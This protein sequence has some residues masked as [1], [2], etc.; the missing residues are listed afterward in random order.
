V[1]APRDG[2]EALDEEALEASTM[3]ESRPGRQTGGALKLSP[4][5]PAGPDLGARIPTPGLDTRSSLE[6]RLT[7]PAP[8]AEVPPAPPP[9][10]QTPLPML[11]PSEPARPIADPWPTGS[12]RR[13]DRL[14]SHRRLAPAAGRGRA[15]AIA[16]GSFLA[17]LLVRDLVRWTWQLARPATAVPA[18]AAGVVAPAA[19]P[20]VVPGRLDPAAP[21]QPAIR[22]PADRP[23]SPGARSAR[24]PRDRAP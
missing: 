12:A 14:A 18:P 16:L 17:G 11:R 7:L 2:D 21:G 3:I 22:P 5:T 15:L 20:A 8:V 6:L 10:V 23:G 9:A 19:G 24:R 13:Q 1:S 4:L